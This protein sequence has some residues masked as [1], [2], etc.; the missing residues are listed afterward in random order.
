MTRSRKCC[1]CI[2]LPLMLPQMRRQA[3]Q[4]CTGSCT[5]VIPVCIP[6]CSQGNQPMFST[7]TSTALP[8]VQLEILFC[9]RP[10]LWTTLGSWGHL[11]RRCWS[12]MRISYASTPLCLSLPQ[13]LNLCR[14]PLPR[15]ALRWLCPHFRHLAHFPSQLL[16]PL[17][18]QSQHRLRVALV[19]LLLL[20]CRRHQK[21]WRGDTKIVTDNPFSIW[22]II[23]TN[24]LM[25]FA[26]YTCD[27]K[28]V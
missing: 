2:S 11:K 17:L 27:F 13:T 21:L 16:L 5:H 18:L 10:M 7:K 22:K 20:W 23:L 19:L 28:D 3:I 12:A 1:W 24:E 25:C 15:I 8:G 4:W 26:D 6:L 9:S 14:V